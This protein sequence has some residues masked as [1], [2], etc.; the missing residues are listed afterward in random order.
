[1][2][3]TRSRLLAICFLALVSSAANAQ[4]KPLLGLIPK[5]V[6]T[7]KMNGKLD[8]WEGAFVTPVHVFGHPDYAN[9]GAEFFYLWDD[10]NLSMSACGTLDQHP[11]DIGPVVQEGDAVEFYLDTRR[12]D[13]LGAAQF[14]PGSL[15]MFWTPF[16]KSD[17]K[18]RWAMRDIPF[19]K[20]LKLPGAEIAGE[21]T[22]WGWTAEFKLPWATFTEFKPK[23]G[24][25]VGIDCE[26][27]SSDGGLRAERTFV[28]SSPTSVGT[29]STFGR[30]KLVEKIDLGEL[31]SFGRA[32]LPMSLTKSG[33]YPWLYGTVGISPTIDKAV[34]KIEGKLLDGK[35]AV[36]KK[37]DGNRKTLA[38]PGF[39]IW[40]GSWELFDLPPGVYTIEISALDKAGKLVTSRTEK[41]LHGNP[42]ETNARK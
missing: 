10:A 20:N 14:T 39:S 38:G 6:K 25:V 5:A 2:I 29:P 34:T 4:E 40:M 19:L 41:F 33:N 17:I 21:K 35:G 3:S 13:Q 15:H 7:I 42:D 24:E 28:Y 22:P 11:M 31:K 9:R 16:T 32:L 36:R 1:M 12:G 23:A 26:L 37:T 8:D 30:V 18:P 27:C